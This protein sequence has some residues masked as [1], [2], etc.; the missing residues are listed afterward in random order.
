[1]PFNFYW[2]VAMRKDDE[3]IGLGWGWKGELVRVEEKS[4]RRGV[5]EWEPPR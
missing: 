5:R 2:M 4:E 1:M 3:E